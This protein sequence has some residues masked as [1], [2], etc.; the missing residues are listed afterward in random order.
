[1]AGGLVY[2]GPWRKIAVGAALVLIIILMKGVVP[3]Q[4]ANDKETKTQQNNSRLLPVDDSEEDP[5]AVQWFETKLKDLKLQPSS[6]K[7]S[8]Y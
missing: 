8:R 3:L 1:M 5:F 4:N 6:F 2:T 7:V